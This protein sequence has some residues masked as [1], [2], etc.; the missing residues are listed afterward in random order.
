MSQAGCHD[1][2][3]TQMQR[4]R[5]HAQRDAR[6]LLSA[7]AHSCHA[8]AADAAER[9][10]P[11]LGVLPRRAWLPPNAIGSFIVSDSDTLTSISS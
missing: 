4:A 7:P 1:I 11:R 8:A 10:P 2:A 5:A 6:Y 9:P 3:A